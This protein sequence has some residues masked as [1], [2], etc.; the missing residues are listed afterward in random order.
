MTTLMVSNLQRHFAG[1]LGSCAL[2][3]S[4][5]ETSMKSCLSPMFHIPVVALVLLSLFA[6]PLAYSQGPIVTPDELKQALVDSSKTRKENLDQV[7]NF[8]S[9]QATVKALN[10]ANL[11]SK[12]LDR[13][14]STLNA[15]EL[16]K[17]AATTR[18]IE[19]DFAAGTLT[20]EQLTYI[21]IALATA[22]IVLIAVH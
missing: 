18:H 2:T 4:M 14:V 7:R 9:R 3:H 15:D 6:C 20:N 8:F 17:L 22:V 1:T 13:A 19:T 5:K 12:R 10:S 16:A 21:V 11:D